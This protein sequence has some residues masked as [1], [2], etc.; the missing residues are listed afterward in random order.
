MYLDSL[1]KI[2]DAPGKLTRKKIKDTVYIDQEYER[3]YD[4]VRKFN[5][6]KRTTIGKLWSDD[7]TLMYPNQNYVR[8]FPEA[9][10]PVLRAGFELSAQGCDGTGESDRT[11]QNPDAAEGHDALT[12]V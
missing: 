12:S 1:V 5:I 11:G 6:P 7:L 3:S 9:Q 10:L 4:P 2:P 8:F